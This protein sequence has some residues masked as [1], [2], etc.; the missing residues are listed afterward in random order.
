MLNKTLN[1]NFGRKTPVFIF[2][3]NFNF[4]DHTEVHKTLFLH[5]APGLLLLPNNL[6]AGI[7][8]TIWTE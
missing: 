2:Y 8:G 1:R 4:H 5:D 3:R 7:L 6:G